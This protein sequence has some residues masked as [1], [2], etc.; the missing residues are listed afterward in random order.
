[1]KVPLRKRRAKSENEVRDWGNRR[2]YG[3]FGVFT[4]GIGV[5]EFDFRVLVF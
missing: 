2:F 4:F 5:V 3:D 1:M